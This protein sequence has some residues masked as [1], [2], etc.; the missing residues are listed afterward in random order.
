MKKITLLLAMI[1]ATVTGS[2]AQV[3]G[4][5][6]SQSSGT[7]SEI[8]G[9]T[10]LGTNTNDDNSFNAQTIGFNF[11]FNNVSYSQISINSNGF[12][13]MGAT[14]SSNSTALSGGT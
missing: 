13:S 10:I 11:V 2:F 12:I 14:V 1:L 7:Y 9:G 8:T 3:S 4:Y 5:V 6:F